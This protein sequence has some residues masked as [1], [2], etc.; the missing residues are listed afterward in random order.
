VMTV[1]RHLLFLLPALSLGAPGYAADGLY[2]GAEAGVVERDVAGFDDAANAGIRI[3]YE[4]QSIGIGDL[5]IEGSYTDSI[6]DGDLPAGAKW[7]MKAFSG[8]GVLRTAGPIYLKGRA[9]FSAW[10]VD[11]GAASDDGTDFSY[12]LGAGLSFGIAQLEIE[13]TVLQDDIK[14]YGAALNIMTPF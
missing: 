3:G 12:G 5:S 2:L 10:D 14:Y 1:R 6:S 7:S 11:A 8:Y 13:Y 4:F 9:G